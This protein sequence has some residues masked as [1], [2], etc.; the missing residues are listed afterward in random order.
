MKFI[1]T[2]E[3]VIEAE[4]KSITLLRAALARFRMQPPPPLEK[5]IASELAIPS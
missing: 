2:M 5:G 1:F 3:F 4:K